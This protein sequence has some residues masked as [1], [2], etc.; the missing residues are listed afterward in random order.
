MSW[1]LVLVGA[2]L[3]ALL[4]A[5]RVWWRDMKAR[6]AWELQMRERMLAVRESVD[7]GPGPLDRSALERARA[8]RAR[9]AKR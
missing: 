7:A 6:R 9:K 1:L 8:K 2:V 4:E 3:G 5:A